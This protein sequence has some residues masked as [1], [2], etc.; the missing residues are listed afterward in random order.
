MKNVCLTIHGLTA[1]GGEER[2]CVLLANELCKRGYKVIVVTLNQMDGETNTYALLPDVKQYT[3]RRNRYERKLFSYKAFESLP[4]IRYRRILRKEEIDVVID[5]DIHQSLIS[6]KAISG[7]KAKVISWDHFNYERFRKRWSYQIMKDCFHSGKVSKLV[8]L[9]KDDVKAY[10]QYESFSDDF[11]RQIYNPSP[12]QTDAYM[13][14]DSKKVLAVGRLTEQKGFDLLLKA[15]AEVERV[16]EDWQLEIVGDGSMKDILEQEIRHLHLRN[17][18]LTPY[19]DNVREKYSS[20]SILVSSSRY[21]G[22]PLVLLESQSMSIPVVSFDY[23]TGPNE[24]IRDGYNGY[25]AEPEN[26][27]MLAEKLI[28]VMRDDAL[29]EQM[30]RNA[31]EESRKFATDKIIR[32]WEELIEE[33]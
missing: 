11:L 26:T 14:H 24:I 10:T 13:P 17:V 12:I 1:L 18:T 33:V 22:F 20:A 31:F 5:V 28:A 6:T 15:W 16:C 29:R 9:T 23:K 30:S 2:M 27:Q 7:T 32:Q 3:L 21:E 8:L 19:T 4:V 25:L